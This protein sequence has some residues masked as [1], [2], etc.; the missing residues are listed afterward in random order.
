MRAGFL[1]GFLLLQTGGQAASGRSMVACLA[2]KPTARWA[3]PSSLR[4][5]SGLALTDDGRLLVHDD[6]KARITEV[7]YRVGTIVKSFQLGKP[8][9]L[10]DFEAIAVAGPRVFLV[11]SAGLLY[12]TREGK[13]GETVPFTVTDTHAGALCEIEG[14]TWEP[15]DHALLLLCKTFGS[16]ALRGTITM[17]RWSPDRKRWL[18][19]GRLGAP[20][21]RRLQRM[22]GS[23]FRGSDLSRDPV[24]GR[25][26]AIA[27]INRVA[28]ELTP[29][30]GLVA[31]GP[32]GKHH[33]QAEG[34]AIAKDGTVLVS[35][36]GGGGPGH[37]TVY[38]CA[39]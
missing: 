23:D 8:A 20:L 9:M 7:N 5:I 34:V 19:P 35:D 16:T 3:L 29:E 26:L 15:R 37:L 18:V 14:L 39:R 13:D 31:I 2:T 17:L 28:A 4:E 6:E 22:L 38:A 10:G 33:P 21:D 36:E 24:T 12:E 30:A 1:V 27:G 11:T 25:Y 32:L